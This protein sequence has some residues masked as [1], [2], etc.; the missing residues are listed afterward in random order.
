MICRACWKKQ[1]STNLR[2]GRI[3]RA[4]IVLVAAIF[5]FVQAASA[6]CA[7]C[8]AALAASPEGAQIAEGF[9]HG[10]LLLMVVPY[11]LLGGFALV[12]YNAYRGQ[13]RESGRIRYLASLNRWLRSLLSR[14]RD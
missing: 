1:T 8:K 6:Q 7:L 11:L 2:A 10:I 5:A 14:S 4:L 3:A 13:K 9:R 12:L